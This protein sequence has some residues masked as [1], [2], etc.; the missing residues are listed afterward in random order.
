MQTRMG[1]AI[2]TLSQRLSGD[3]QYDFVFTLFLSTSLQQ[4]LNNV[5]DDIFSSINCH[6]VPLLEKVLPQPQG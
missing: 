3:H 6:Q 5:L 4:N 1:P 2:L